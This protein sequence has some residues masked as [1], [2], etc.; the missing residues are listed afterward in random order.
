MEKLF[1]AL[2]EHPEKI[3]FSILFTG[4]LIYTMRVNGIR[5]NRY[6]N[7]IDKLTDALKE[8]DIVKEM[9]ERLERK[10]K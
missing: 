5:E 10:Y 7:T 4:L 2:A 3:S 6:Q 8:L 9:I 1:T